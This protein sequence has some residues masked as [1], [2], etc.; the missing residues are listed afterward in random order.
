M[1]SIC[2]DAKTM[3]QVLENIGYHIND[4]G[5]ALQAVEAGPRNP[6]WVYTVGLMESFDHPELVVTHSEIYAAADLLNTIGD[7]VAAGARVDPESTLDLDGYVFEFV[8]VHL[9]YIATGLC[10][11]WERYYTWT[12]ARR[13]ALPEVLQVVVPLAEWCERC[14]RRRRCLATP[15]T[16]GFNVSRAARRARPPHERWA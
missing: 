2:D 1:C 12:G 4:R 7:R 13:R 5:W 9:A 14:D 11:S 16:H 8:A 6:S 15:G 3:E 10:A